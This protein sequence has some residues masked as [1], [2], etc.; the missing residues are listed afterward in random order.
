MRRSTL[1]CAEEQHRTAAWLVLAAEIALA[2]PDLEVEL[3]QGQELLKGYGDTFDRG[4]AN[5]E[6]ILATTREIRGGPARQD[7]FARCGR[8]RSR[9]TT[10]R[11]CARRSKSLEDDQLAAAAR[12]RGRPPLAS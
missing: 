8:R 4:L 2:D 10:A 5:F 3:V 7:T 6:T 11:P 12:P 9:T 1:R